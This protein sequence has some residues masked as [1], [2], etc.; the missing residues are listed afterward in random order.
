[1]FTSTLL[2]PNGFFRQCNFL[3]GWVSFINTAWSC[4]KAFFFKDSGGSLMAQAWLKAKRD[5]QGQGKE[6]PTKLRQAGS[7]RWFKNGGGGHPFFMTQ[8]LHEVETQK[9]AVEPLGAHNSVLV[10]HLRLYSCS[11]T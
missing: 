7:S 6:K 3:K 4:W 5:Q 2:Q 8:T 10:S 9:Q 1:M 11:P